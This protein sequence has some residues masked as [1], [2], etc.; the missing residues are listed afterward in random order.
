MTPS[1]SLPC[2]ALALAAALC[3]RAAVAH[4]ACIAI[5]PRPYRAMG[6]GEAVAQ[7]VALSAWAPHLA[8]LAVGAG[9]LLVAVYALSGAGWLTPLPMRHW[10]LSAAAAALWA[11]ALGFPL[12]VRRFPGNSTR[13]SGWCRA[14]P[15]RC[16]AACC[17]GVCGPCGTG[18]GLADGSHA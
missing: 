2:L 13:V 6:A 9:L 11:R 3:V 15:A 17:G 4:F 5:G 14:W 10:V 1:I 7:A 16:W 18:P 12:L 8:A